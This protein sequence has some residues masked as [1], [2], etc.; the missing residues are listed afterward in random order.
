M[1]KRYDQKQQFLLPFNLEEFVPEN[2]IVRV[3]NDI[4]DVINRTYAVEQ[5]KPVA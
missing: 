3:L 1:F 5:K 2:H 4:I